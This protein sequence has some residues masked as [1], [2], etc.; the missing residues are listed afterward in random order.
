MRP[1]LASWLSVFALFLL[2]RLVLAGECQPIDWKRT[3]LGAGDINCRREI[4]TGAD[5]DSSTCA[6]IA[7]RY[8]VTVENLVELN[9][10]LDKD[11]KSIKPE[12]TYCVAGFREPLRAFDG[13]CG[14]NHNDATCIGTDKQCCNKNTWKCGDTEED[15]GSACYEGVCN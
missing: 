14:P 8:R 1:S 15:C 4:K 7:E 5:V 12:A 6:S 3:A 10:G 11:C 9:P 2:N 13:L